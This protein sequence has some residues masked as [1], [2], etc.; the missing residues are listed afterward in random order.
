M[1]VHLKIS[2]IIV[3]KENEIGTLGDKVVVSG[4]KNPEDIAY[5]K[6]V[7]GTNYIIK[8]KLK[9]LRLK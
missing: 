1:D 7:S 3:K 8:N 6:N 2:L 4:Q 9:G 5:V